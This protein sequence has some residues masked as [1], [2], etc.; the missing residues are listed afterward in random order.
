MQPLLLRW[1]LPSC[2]L[3]AR[4]LAGDP[5]VLLADE[6]TQH[7]DPACAL[8]LL[9]LLQEKARLGMAVAVVLHDLSL[10][11][12][13]DAIYLLHCGECLA[14]GTPSAVL[15]DELLAASYGIRVVRLTYEDGE[16]LVPIQRI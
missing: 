9:T 5:Q 14:W 11:A 16:T 10:A 15:T 7:L 6:P 8:G 2:A 12:R 3:R 4:A 13:C 1:P